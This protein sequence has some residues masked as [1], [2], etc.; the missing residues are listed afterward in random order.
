MERMQERILNKQTGS[1]VITGQC[2]SVPS[3]APFPNANT[4]ENESH[5][6]RLKTKRVTQKV[7]YEV[8]YKLRINGAFMKQPFMKQP[9]QDSHLH[10]ITRSPSSRSSELQRNKPVWHESRTW[11]TLLH[12]YGNAELHGNEK[13]Q[14]QA[15]ECIKKDRQEQFITKTLHAH[16]VKF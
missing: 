1:T 16:C 9:Y 5:Q 4:T 15:G 2:Q 13:I 8:P 7:L 3:S 11:L 10:W 6:C 14:A 12:F